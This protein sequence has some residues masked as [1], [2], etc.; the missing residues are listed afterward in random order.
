MWNMCKILYSSMGWMIAVLGYVLSSV[1]W[2]FRANRMVAAFFGVP[3]LS[4]IL[5]ENAHLVRI[6]SSL[7][8][9]I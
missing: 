9:S 2:D 7:Q 6:F 5:Q 8:E 1:S 3:K 4:Y